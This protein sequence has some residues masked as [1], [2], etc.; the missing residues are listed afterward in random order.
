MEEETNTNCCFCK[1]RYLTDVSIFTS[2]FPATMSPSSS[3]SF[4]SHHNSLKLSATMTKIPSPNVHSNNHNEDLELIVLVHLKQNYNLMVQ[5]HRAATRYIRRQSSIVE[6]AFPNH[7]CFV[8][9]SEEGREICVS[10]ILSGMDVSP[11]VIQE[12]VPLITSFCH[13]KATEAVQAEQDYLTISMDIEISTTKVLKAEKCSG[14]NVGEECMICL[15][16]FLIGTVVTSMPCSHMFH[17]ARLHC[18]MVEGS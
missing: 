12:L 13:E 3:S 17:P 11:D 15:D 16:V 6:D 7:H 10:H 18:W 14:T 5:S 1:I 8:S 2:T 4:T 9:L